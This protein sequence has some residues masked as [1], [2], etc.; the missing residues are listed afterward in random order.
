[1]LLYSTRT[2]RR[3]QSSFL[4]SERRLHGRLHHADEQLETLGVL[5]E[6]G[7]ERCQGV[8]MS[9]QILQGN[10]LTKVGLREEEQ[11]TCWSDSA[12]SS[13]IFFYSSTTIL[14]LFLYFLQKCWSPLCSTDE[15]DKSNIISINPADFYDPMTSNFA[16]AADW[17]FWTLWNIGTFCRDVLG[18]QRMNPTVMGLFLQQHHEP[19]GLFI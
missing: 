11:T 8:G 7:G 15:G 16:A 5:G 13:S 10:P 18:S 12:A 14:W 1:M 3:T 4:T 17:K 2:E 19:A 6:A 9:A